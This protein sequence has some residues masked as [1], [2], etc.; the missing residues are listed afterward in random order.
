ME[1]R[2]LLAVT[3]SFLVLAG[4]QY[5]FVKP[6]PRTA[7]KAAATASETPTAGAAPAQGAPPQPGNSAQ[8][9]PTTVSPVEP[10]ADVEALVTDSAERDVVVETPKIQAVFSNRGAELKSWHLK[11]YRDD[12]GHPVDLVPEGVPPTEPRAFALVA[13]DPA[14]TQRMRSALYRPSAT[15][16]NVADGQKTIPFDYQDAAGLLVRKTFEFEA[17]GQPYELKF[18]AEVRQDGQPV[19]VGVSSGPGLGDTDRAQ[20]SGGFFSPSYYQKPQAIYQ[21]DKKVNRLTWSSIQ[22]APNY[23]GRFHYAG[24]DDHYFLS[25]FLPAD[26]A[27]KVEYKPFAIPAPQ[28]QRELLTYTLRSDQAWHDARFFL[29]PKQFDMLAATDKELVR[30]INFG[31]FD[32]LVVPLL[33]ALNAVNQFVGNYGWSII[34]L[35][36]IINLVMW[37]LRHKSMVSMRKM[38]S[39]QPQVKAIQDRYANLKMTDPVATEDE[40][41]VD[42]PLPGEGGQSGQRLRADVAD[43]PGVVRLLLPAVPGH[44]VARR[45]LLRLDYG[46]VRAGPLVRHAAADGRD[47]VLAAA[48]DTVDRRPRTA[49][50][51]D[52]HAGDVH[53][54]VPVGAERPGGVLAGQQPVR[55]RPAVRHEPDAGWAS[56]GSQPASGREGL[57]PRS[58]R[59]PFVLRTRSYDETGL[60]Q[61]LIVGEPGWRRCE[62][63][64]RR[65]S[66]ESTHFGT[67]ERRDTR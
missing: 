10:V 53:L 43:L 37:P 50:G 44:R 23:E 16:L 15:T 58:H 56:R 62:N 49:E 45:A 66:C 40:H 27:V 26:H 36:L 65:C 54:H 35:T 9:G 63:T 48:H 67:A 32:W 46:P 57:N 59:H 4:Y 47:H 14:S 25:V 2:V 18:S 61:D 5:F 55:H 39:L 19:P 34:L 38:Q 1:K 33:R 52:V 3:L 8:P 42:E 17:N 64:I 11:D 7:Q 51:H 24:T 6:L 22:T 13:A 30:T 29:G 60:A 21:Q 41:R 12:Q 31:M 28:G 20:S